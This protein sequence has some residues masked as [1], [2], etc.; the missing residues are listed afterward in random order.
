MYAIINPLERHFLTF[1]PMNNVQLFIS[2]LRQVKANESKLE[3]IRS[4]DWP[5]HVSNKF[6]SNIPLY[7]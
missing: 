1:H 4:I 7:E 2:N 3:T 6:L 5:K